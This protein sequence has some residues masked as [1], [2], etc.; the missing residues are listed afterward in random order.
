[1]AKYNQIEVKEM[2][3]YKDLPYDRERVKQVMEEKIQHSNHD[4][5][6][7]DN[8]LLRAERAADDCIGCGHCDSRCPF[9]VRQSE[10]MQEIRNYMNM[11]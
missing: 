9:S 5:Q 10:R 6:I 4:L 2:D 1:M 3:N 8:M 7:T 11:H